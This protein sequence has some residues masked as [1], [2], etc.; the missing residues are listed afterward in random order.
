MP[1]RTWL[2]NRQI[3]SVCH[4]LY[5]IWDAVVLY[6]KFAFLRIPLDFFKQKQQSSRWLT[7]TRQIIGTA[8]GILFV[9]PFIHLIRMT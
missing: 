9:F 4:W 3:Y 2:R 6:F 5:C 7:G 1:F 8:G